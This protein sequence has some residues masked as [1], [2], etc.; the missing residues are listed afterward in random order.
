ML[1]NILFTRTMAIL[2]KG[3]DA[4]SMRNRVIANNLA[5]IDTPGYKRSEVVFEDELK[6]AIGKNGGIRGFITNEKHIPIGGTGFPDINPSQVVKHDT[7]MRNDGNNVDID[8]EM[9]ALAKNTIMFEALSQE[10]KGE[11]EKIKTAIIEGGR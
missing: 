9:A 11:F 4:A 7:S 10:I 5:N 3:L 1:E 2:E 8:R 6:K